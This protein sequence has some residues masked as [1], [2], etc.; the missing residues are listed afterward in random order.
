MLTRGWSCCHCKPKR[1]ASGYSHASEVE[2]ELLG[3]CVML[4]W[5]ITCA[6]TADVVIA[7]GL[8]APLPVAHARCEYY[9]YPTLCRVAKYRYL[10]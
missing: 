6:C 4:S 7:V 1:R 5:Y 9:A 10:R 3:R 8:G 2:V